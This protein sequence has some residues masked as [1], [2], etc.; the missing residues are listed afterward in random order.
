[1]NHAV[2]TFCLLAVI[3][4]PTVVA[5]QVRTGD[6]TTGQQARSR[7]SPRADSARMTLVGCLEPA[8]GNAFALTVV[9]MPAAAKASAGTRPR[10][11]T[12]LPGR[13]EPGA[14]GTTGLNLVGQRVHLIGR[15]QTD[16]GPHSGHKIEVTGTMVPHGSTR[17]AA[18]PA[19]GMRL[20][21]SNIRHISN[22]CTPAVGSTGS[23]APV[24]PNRSG[25]PR[26]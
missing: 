25:H 14:T 3:S 2:R 23:T 8:T 19:A 18:E 17:G 7:T 22:T 4:W 5:A 26:R 10:A 24:D 11:G 20:N 21:V 12:R 16:L 13:V 1:M 15:T 6:E 9:E